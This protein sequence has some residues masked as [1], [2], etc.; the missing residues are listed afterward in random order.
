MSFG[1]LK[2]VAAA[3]AVLAFAPFVEARVIEVT[4]ENLAPEDSITFAPLRVGFHNGTFDAF[5]NG[6]MAGDA[7]ISVA[8][9]GSGNLWFPAFEAADP[10]A[11]LGSVLDG[12]PLLPGTSASVLFDVDPMMNQ[13]FTFAAMVVPSN[14]LFIG[15]DNPMQYQLFDL[16]GNLNLTEITLFGSD[17]WDA[18]SEVADPANAAFIEGGM[19]PLRT[20]E[21]DVVNFSFDEL[22][23]FDGLTTAAGYVFDTQ[24]TGATEIYRITFAEVASV[25]EPGTAGLMLLG[26]L[27]LIARRRRNA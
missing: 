23:V 8:E 22:N 16:S 4:V 27:A 18:G 7:I 14:D 21:N 19:N 24:I 13:F 26:G 6:E 17:I 9:G 1:K 3:S 10:T 15:N 11:T 2:G 12:G 5:N 20:A 25:P